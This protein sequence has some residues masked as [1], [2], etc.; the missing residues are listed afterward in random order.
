VRTIKLLQNPIKNSAIFICD[1]LKRLKFQ[2][3]IKSYVI[4]SGGHHTKQSIGTEERSQNHLNYVFLSVWGLALSHHS[5]YIL[6]EH[7]TF[8]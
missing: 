5:I 7:V 6:C 4:K 1:V 2:I 8:F 3:S